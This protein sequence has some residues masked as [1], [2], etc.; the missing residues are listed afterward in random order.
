MGAEPATA[1][2]TERGADSESDPDRTPN[3]AGTGAPSDPARIPSS[4]T[5]PSRRGAGLSP[6][7]LI[8]LVVP[9][10]LISA[11]MVWILLGLG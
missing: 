3:A 5:A 2:R 7:G 6:A 8:A 4:G 11:L 1:T 9:V 10:F